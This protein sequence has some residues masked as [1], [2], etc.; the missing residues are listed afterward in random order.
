MKTQ[1]PIISYVVPAYGRSSFLIECIN[2]LKKQDFESQEI[3]IVD[4]CSEPPLA[5]TLSEAQLEGVTIVRHPQNMGPSAARN[6]GADSARGAFLIFVDNDD[7]ALDGLSRIVAQRLDPKVALLKWGWYTGRTLES[8]ELFS[9]MKDGYR[10][11]PGTF[12]IKKE[13]FASLGGYQ[14]ELRFAENTELSIRLRSRL[15]L[16]KEKEKEKQ[17]EEPLIFRRVC[18]GQLTSR[19]DRIAIQRRL[20]AAD[21][22]LAV[23]SDKL[24][25]K[26]KALYLGISGVCLLRLN[27]A[28]D[29]RACFR[30]SN[31]M[32]PGGLKG[33]IRILLTYLPFGLGGVVSRT[34]PR[35]YILLEKVKARL[36]LPSF[37][38]QPP[39][40]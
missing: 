27:R 33:V 12:A 14:Q 25:K 19:L 31:T 11:L 18:K 30:A 13:V 4:D 15:C 39:Y 9:P 38:R 29:A 32:K 5:E 6:T 36:P 8:S 3:V 24:S 23:H 17:M 7:L 35:L 34:L 40:P 26:H 20:A 21:Y 10:L 28:A 37:L 2:S 1:T 22:I 16:S